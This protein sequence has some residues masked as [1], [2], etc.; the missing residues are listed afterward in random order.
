MRYGT[1][2]VLFTDDPSQGGTTPPTLSGQFCYNNTE[3][4]IAGYMPEDTVVANLSAWNV[5]ELTESEFL[6]LA[7]TVYPLAYMDDNG[8][9]IIPKA[10][11]IV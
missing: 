4:N 10:S 9:I 11:F 3:T 2:I 1:W 8:Y 5:V 6:D 7:K